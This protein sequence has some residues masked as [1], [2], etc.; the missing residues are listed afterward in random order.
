MLTMSSPFSILHISDLHRS[1]KDPISND[2]LI[3]ALVSDRDRYTHEDP[4]VPH[5]K[6]VV[7]SGDIIQGVGLGADNYS[8]P[9]NNVRAAIGLEESWAIN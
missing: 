7:V 8:N 9:L 2:E 1:P 6:A 5:P 4:P 3:S